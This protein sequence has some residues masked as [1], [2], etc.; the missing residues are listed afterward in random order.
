MTV[1]KTNP[2]IWGAVAALICVAIAV[3][4][5]MT[6]DAPDNALLRNPVSTAIVGF[7][8]GWVAGNAKNWYGNRLNRR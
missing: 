5:R 7:F 6:G 2:L 1:Q 3:I 4:G 8:W